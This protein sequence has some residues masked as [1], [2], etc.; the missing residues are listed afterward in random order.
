Q[1]GKDKGKC[2]IVVNGVRRLVRCRRNAYL[3]ADD[4]HSLEAVH[5]FSKQFQCKGDPS[6][7]G[8]IG[9]LMKQIDPAKDCI[10]GLVITS[11]GTRERDL[12]QM[13]K[14]GATNSRDLEDV[15]KATGVTRHNAKAYF[16]EIQK[17]VKFCKPCKIWLIACFSGSA[18]DN[19]DN[20]LRQIHEAT[21]CTV[22]APK[23]LCVLLHDRLYGGYPRLR[24]TTG[25][26]EFAEDYAMTNGLAVYPRDASIPTAY[27]LGDF[28]EDLHDIYRPEPYFTRD[29]VR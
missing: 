7:K 4:D 25:F 24:V 12:F 2:F 21:G 15:T 23:G 11:H 20:L 9:M 19:E 16:D 3:V 29:V 1:S 13:T 22:Y 26:D 28:D 6:L 8:V 14:D 18:V 5:K 10:D 17:N 27:E